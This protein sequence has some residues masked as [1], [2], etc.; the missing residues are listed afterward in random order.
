MPPAGPVFLSIPLDD[1]DKEIDAEPFIRHVST[2]TAP[3]PA[4]L[5]QFADLIS[6][7][8]KLAL[9]YGEEVDQSLGWEAG[10]ALAELL[11]APV[12]QAPLASRA[13]FPSNNPLYQGSL[14]IAQAP[15]SEALAHFDTVLVV[16]AEVF[17]YYPYI[18]GP[19]LQN[20]TQLLQI[21][22]SPHDA[23]AARV[24]DA[25]LSDARLALE[26]LYLLLSKNQ[27]ST[28]T[29]TTSAQAS[30]AS[31]ASPKPLSKN[32]GSSLMTAAEAFQAAA[33]ARHKSDLLVQ[34]SPS[35]VQDLL[36]AWPI[37]EQATYFTSASGFLGWGLPAAVGI[38]MA[39]TN[40]TTVLALGDG[41]MQ[42]S[43]QAIYSAV[44]HKAKL[45]ILVPRNDE[46]AIL[47]E[48][49]IFEKTPNCRKCF[50]ARNKWGPP[51]D[52]DL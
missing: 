19:V 44:Q 20:G 3:D 27:T 21:T 16:G 52:C 25:I 45:I 31:S 32:N 13:V 34:E 28:P 7:S 10:V 30:S 1:F 37:V 47:K 49:A 51:A 17:R 24:G 15:V 2:T 22:N 14:P 36:E 38:A 11:K 8:K 6:K 35:N 33:L 26:S 18:N 39:Q 48:F 42:Y 50:I 4:M 29:S 46:Y 9:V 41:S 12:F 40:R 23:G 5:A 43:V